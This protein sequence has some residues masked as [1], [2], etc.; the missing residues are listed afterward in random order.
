MFIY[1]YPLY[2]K[3]SFFIKYFLSIVFFIQFAI[4]LLLFFFILTNDCKVF[5]T[6]KDTN[7]KAFIHGALSQFHTN[8]PKGSATSK[9]KTEN[10]KSFCSKIISDCPKEL[11]PY[12]LVKGHLFAM[13]I[14]KSAKDFLLNHTQGFYTCKNRYCLK[15]FIE[16]GLWNFV[17][18]NRMI[19]S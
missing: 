16:K 5:F 14:V 7:Y 1:K 15:V 11:F 18:R 8:F 4:D 19:L 2:P 10:Q 17:N 12:F 3:N 9:Q 6:R 13:Y